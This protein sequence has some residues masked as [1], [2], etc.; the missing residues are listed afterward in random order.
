MSL[1]ASDITAV[2]ALTGLTKLHLGAEDL[3]D[4]AECP[5]ISAGCFSQLTSLSFGP[6]TLDA[7]AL[8]QVLSKQIVGPQCRLCIVPGADLDLEP[9]EDAADDMPIPFGD[10]D[11]D[12]EARAEQMALDAAESL[13]QALER[14]ALQ[15]SLPGA[16]PLPMA[17]VV[18]ASSYDMAANAATHPDAQRAQRVLRALKG[19]QL[20]SDLQTA[21]LSQIKRHVD[22]EAPT[23]WLLDAMAGVEVLAINIM[24]GDLLLGT[25]PPVPRFT[26]LARALEHGALPAL[27]Q[28]VIVVNEAAAPADIDAAVSSIPALMAAVAAPAAAAAAAA[29]GAGGSSSQVPPDASAGTGPGRRQLRVTLYGPKRQLALRQ[30]LA[31]VRARVDV[32]EAVTLSLVEE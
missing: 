6:H 29:Q 17:C 2:A 3:Y 26:A 31:W 20:G 8:Q 19:V 27:R 11:P 32:P 4:L 9:F 22:M 23:C 10:D 18:H 7:L 25:S 28:L 15:G 5:S 24:D 13:A 16:G 30:A 14:H 21:F 12:F 1:S